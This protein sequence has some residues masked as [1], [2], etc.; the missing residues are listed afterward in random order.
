ISIG[1]TTV[2]LT[3]TPIDIIPDA[4]IKIADDI[5]VVTNAEYKD[6]TSPVTVKLSRP[7][8]AAQAAG[9]A[10]TVD[11]SC[12][13]IRLF[14][15]AR[16][17]FYGLNVPNSAQ[18]LARNITVQ[19][20]FRGSYVYDV[21]AQ[22][23][24]TLKVRGCNFL[25]GAQSGAGA[26]IK[27]VDGCRD[28]SIDENTFENN[29]TG[30][31]NVDNNIYMDAT[32]SATKGSGNKF[33]NAKG[34]SI[35]TFKTTALEMLNQFPNNWFNPKIVNPFTVS[36]NVRVSTIGNNQVAYG[37]GI[38]DYGRWKRGDIVF[39]DTP[40]VGSPIGWRCTGSGDQGTWVS[41]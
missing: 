22:G 20:D 23:V 9:V 5:Y 38:P 11:R 10:V 32:V 39:N 19:R 30:L 13:D 18:S 14:G 36:T 41:F 28:V 27:V 25:E 12:A 6:L 16:G 35:R 29:I 37:S 21:Y 17:Y 4:Y 34:D 40:S 31:T 1:D 8:A 33:Y 26:N 24:R 3:T 2:T 7:I 15:S